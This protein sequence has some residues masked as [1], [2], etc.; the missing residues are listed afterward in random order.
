MAR[1]LDKYHHMEQ[2][3]KYNVLS[4][5]QQTLKQLGELLRVKFNGQEVQPESA[6]KDSAAFFLNIILK[7]YRIV[8][9]V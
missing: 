5:E 7:N 3:N 2:I 9:P 8:N 4:N 6:L 1:G